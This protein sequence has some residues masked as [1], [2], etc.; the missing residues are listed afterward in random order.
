MNDAATAAVTANEKYIL[1]RLQAEEAKKGEASKLKH[2]PFVRLFDVQHGLL[3]TEQVRILLKYYGVPYT[4]STNSEAAM[5]LLVT[6]EVVPKN[7]VRE[8][9]RAVKKAAVLVKRTIGEHSSLYGHLTRVV[10]QLFGSGAAPTWRAWWVT[11]GL[12]NLEQHKLGFHMDCNR[13][14]FYT[15][16]CARAADIAQR[17]DTDVRLPWKKHDTN[18]ALPRGVSHL[19]Q[20]MLRMYTL[21]PLFQQRLLSTIE[22]GRSSNLECFFHLVCVHH[23][24][25]TDWGWYADYASRVESG[26]D[27]GANVLSYDRATGRAVLRRVAVDLER[28]QAAPGARARPA[29]HLGQAEEHFIP[30]A[31]LP[32]GT[33]ARVGSG[34]SEGDASTSI[35]RRLVHSARWHRQR[36]VRAPRAQCG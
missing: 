33:N 3:N 23:P 15:T 1:Q 9:E 10:N 7:C 16:C 18:A 29:L 28:G 17:Q 25:I 5:R 2:P 11:H 24:A 31:A 32:S 14:L 22:F 4:S 19:A 20:L 6:S 35:C 13:Y 8:A 36:A 21:G 30:G 27:I 34:A 26:R 12:L